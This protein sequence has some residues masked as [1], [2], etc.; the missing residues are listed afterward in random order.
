M[1]ATAICEEIELIAEA[2]DAEDALD[3]SR[4]LARETDTTRA[5]AVRRTVSKGQ[6]DRAALRQLGLGIAEEVARSQLWAAREFRALTREMAADPIGASILA[7]AA[8]E[9]GRLF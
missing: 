6:V 1:L 2:G 3:L 9:A 8:G 5:V 4:R 7:R